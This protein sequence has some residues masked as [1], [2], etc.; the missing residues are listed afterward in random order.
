MVIIY[1]DEGIAPSKGDQASIFY[2]CNKVFSFPKLAVFTDSEDISQLVLAF[3]DYD[4]PYV[5]Q[6]MVITKLWVVFTLNA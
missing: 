4:E 5:N 3:S 2:M 1:L 6:S